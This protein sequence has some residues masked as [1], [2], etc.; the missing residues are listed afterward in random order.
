MH[1]KNTRLTALVPALAAIAAAYGQ[2]ADYVR[3]PIATDNNAFASDVNDHGDIVFRTLELWI[4]GTH[5]S[6]AQWFGL[7]NAPGYNFMP[8]IN[9]NRVVVATAPVPGTQLTRGLTFDAHTGELD[10]LPTLGGPGCIARDINDSN[11]VC[12]L[13]AL[14]AGNSR[15]VIWQNGL[16][17]D[18][19]PVDSIFSEAVRI[20]NFGHVVVDAYYDSAPDHRFIWKNGLF[21]PV[22]DVPVPAGLGI[23]AVVAFDDRDR[24]VVQAGND[25]YLVEGGSFARLIVLPVNQLSCNVYDMGPRGDIVGWVR[26]TT[27]PSSQYSFIMR[28]DGDVTLFPTTDTWTCVNR[29]GMVCGIGRTS[30]GTSSAL[31]VC[32]RGDANCDGSVNNFDIDAFVLAITDAGNYVVA[33]DCPST[34]VVDCNADQATNNF[35]IDAFVQLLLG[36]P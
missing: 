19:S 28:P 3:V 6:L 16:A 20:N 31:A 25:A 12:G 30:P 21:E 1:R 32:L 17:I 22:P 2:T 9:N 23:G 24:L 15:A 34:L 13:A 36:T 11:I 14:W 4:D 29:G 26:Y 33:T 7:T 8:R 10:W 18:I 35:D 27:D 5:A